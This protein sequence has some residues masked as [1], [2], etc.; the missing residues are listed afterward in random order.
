MVAEAVD[1]QHAVLRWG[2]GEEE[3]EGQ[4]VVGV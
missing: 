3:E 1:Y 4:R 2:G